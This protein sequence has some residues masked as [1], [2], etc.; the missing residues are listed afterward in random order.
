MKTKVKSTA[1][2]LTFAAIMA[3][4][5]TW[6]T[7]SPN[8]YHGVTNDWYNANFSNVL[9]RAELRLASN[10][11]DIVGVTLK[12]SYH[13]AFGDINALS[14]SVIRFIQV[15]D[16]VPAP[17]FSNEYWTIRPQEIILRDQ[18][19]PL[20]TQQ[21]IDTDLPKARLPHKPIPDRRYLKALWDD[22]QW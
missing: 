10:S 12:R 3:T 13:I 17:S 19:L 11:N 16:T 18:V 14:N 21:M 4:C 20:F 2:S 7:P 1:K 9:E 6:A 22:G 8:T 15:A 5:T